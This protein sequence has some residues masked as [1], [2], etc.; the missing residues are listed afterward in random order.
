[1]R[2]ARP[3]PPPHPR[4]S[5]RV[6]H[7]FEPHFKNSGYA[8]AYTSVTPTVLVYDCRLTNTGCV[9]RAPPP[10]PPSPRRVSIRVHAFAPHF[11]IPGYIPMHTY[12]L[13]NLYWLTIVGRQITGAWPGRTPRPPPPPMWFRLCI[14]IR[15][16]MSIIPCQLVYMYVPWNHGFMLHTLRLCNRF[17]T[18]VWPVTYVTLS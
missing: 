2:G 16:S 6:V 15:I 18:C 7:V 8:N 1:M 10:P 9:G 17:V 11:K 3:P 14:C 5:I 12:Q 4:V 13:H